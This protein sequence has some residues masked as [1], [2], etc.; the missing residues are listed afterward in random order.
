MLLLA[1]FLKDA[2]WSV[3]F[4]VGGWPDLAQSPLGG[5]GRRRRVQIWE[6]EELGRGPDRWVTA[7]GFILSLGTG[8]YF[9]SFQSQRAMGLFQFAV[10]LNVLL[11]GGGRRR[12][13][14]VASDFRG[15]RDLGL[16]FMF[17]R[18]LCDVWLGQLSM[19]PCCTFSVFVRVLVRFP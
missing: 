4:V 15:S 3:G 13:C 5:G 12:G 8:V 19:Y 16:I 6:L 11:D 14:R 18:V 2:L 7:D 1:F 17:F 10:M 9:D